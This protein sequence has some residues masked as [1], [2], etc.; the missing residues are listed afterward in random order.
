MGSLNNKQPPAIK[1]L[2]IPQLLLKNT[3]PKLFAA[4]RKCSS[5]PCPLFS[6]GCF[7]FPSP[8]GKTTHEKQGSP[9]HF[10]IISSGTRQ[11]CEGA[12]SLLVLSREHG[13]SERPSDSAKAT[14]LCWKP[15]FHLPTGQRQDPQTTAPCPKGWCDTAAAPIPLSAPPPSSV[16]IL[17]PPCSFCPLLIL[18][19]TSLHPR[20]P[21]PLSSFNHHPQG[22]TLK[23]VSHPQRVP[24]PQSS[25][26]AN[27][28]CPPNTQQLLA[29]GGSIH[30][31]P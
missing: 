16:S 2:L 4:S 24:K 7:C 14:R 21:P 9:E 25:I 10:Y 13:S 30:K 22:V 23:S 1:H 5:L 6:P 12:I 3:P 28:P 31:E 19:P 11:L 15:G 18:S 29:A 8:R 27:S 17:P 20:P 26:P